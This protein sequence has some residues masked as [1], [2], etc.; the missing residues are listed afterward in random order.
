MHSASNAG[1]AWPARITAAPAMTT[2]IAAKIVP[3]EDS[4]SVHGSA[5]HNGATAADNA[6]SANATSNAPNPPRHGRVNVTPGDDASSNTQAPQP[7]NAAAWLKNVAEGGRLYAISVGSVTAMRAR[8]SEAGLGPSSASPNVA[9]A[10]CSGM[11]RIVMEG[12]RAPMRYPRATLWRSNR[13][14]RIGT[15]CRIAR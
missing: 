2:S 1:C 15:T 5:A 4:A 12:T 7:M 9:S 3:T 11:R 14:K 8:A 10:R 13:S 6:S